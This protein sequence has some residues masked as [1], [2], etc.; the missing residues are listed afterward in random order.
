[1]LISSSTSS[2]FS[3]ASNKNK[4]SPSSPNGTADAVGL[5]KT[6][7]HQL[8]RSVLGSPS[9]QHSKMAQQ[10]QAQYEHA[11][12]IVI[13]Q[14]SPSTQQ[15]ALVSSSSSSAPFAQ[16][17]EYMSVQDLM[18]TNHHL[19]KSRISPPP[20]QCYQQQ[21]QNSPPVPLDVALVEDL[22]F[23]F[24]LRNGLASNE[25]TLANQNKTASN[26]NTKLKNA[27]GKRNGNRWF[28]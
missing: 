8:T 27:G 22:R 26:S 21:Q 5:S 23:C 9:E 3:T 2:N 28:C 11:N 18:I 17:P 14:S 20:L 4:S 7:Q 1:M 6:M 19:I 24:S 10:Q 15:G 16:S 13:E 12:Y 25:S